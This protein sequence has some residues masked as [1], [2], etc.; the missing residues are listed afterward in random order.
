MKASPAICSSRSKSGARPFGVAVMSIK[1]SSSTSFSLK[2]RTLLYRIADV[3]RILELD[4]LTSP[5]FR[6]SMQRG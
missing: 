5:L 2:I 1:A 3:A 6:R 4:G